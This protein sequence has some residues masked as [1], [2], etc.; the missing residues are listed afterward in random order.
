MP[1]ISMLGGLTEELSRADVDAEAVEV[2][3]VEYRRA[4][5]SIGRYQTVVGEVE[6]ER[7]L[8]RS[9]KILD[10]FH[11]TEHIA[12]APGCDLRGRQRQV[13]DEVQRISRPPARRPEG[14]PKGHPFDGLL[15]E[16]ISQGRE[17]H[18]GAHLS[19]EAPP[20]DAVFGV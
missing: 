10:F 17:A 7:T 19:S 6:V 15:E 4:V 13:S 1:S 14:Y 3:G 20:Q 5:R 2:N 16:E 9:R 18:E 11:A 12:A 8:Y